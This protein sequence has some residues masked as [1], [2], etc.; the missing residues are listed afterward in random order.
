MKSTIRR[1]TSLREDDIRELWRFR[2]ELV[3]LKP[4]VGPEQDFAAFADDF[5]WP[6]FVWILRDRGRVAGFFLQRGVPMRW[7]GRPILCLLPEYGFV[8]PHLRGRPIVPLA[9][10]LITLLCIGRHPLRPRY[11]AASTYPPGYVAFRRAIRPFWTVGA[12]DLPPRERDLLLH[13]GARVSG[14]K[15]R[16]EDGTVDMRTIPI[17]TREPG[18]SGDPESRRLYAAYAAANPEWRAGR[19]LFFLFPLGAAQIARVVVHAGE[20]LFARRRGG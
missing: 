15:F 8:A 4:T 18:E 9:A 11:V 10:L 5:R 19:G 3:R 17:V 12:P 20:R 7:A 14:D 6:G 16:P 13:L 2:L 1:A